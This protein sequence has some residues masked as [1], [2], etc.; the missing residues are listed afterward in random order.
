MNDIFFKSVNTPIGNI[1]IMVS[2]KGVCWVGKEERFESSLAWIQKISSFSKPKEDKKYPILIKAEK[3]LLDYF[4]KKREEFTLPL[5]LYGTPFQKRVWEEISKVPSGETITYKEL[6]KNV[7]NLLAVRAI[8]TTCGQNPI[9][10][11]IPCHRVIGSSGKLTGFVEGI[12]VK[13]QLLEL[14]KKSFQTKLV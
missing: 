14:E 1:I 13:K 8:G 9:I 3:Q 2:Q 5:D 12:E 11:F 6:A 10:I 4:G 7:D